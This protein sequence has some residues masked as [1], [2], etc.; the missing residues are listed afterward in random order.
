MVQRSN[1]EVKISL[2]DCEGTDEE[3]V[4]MVVA[5]ADSNE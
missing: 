5:V 2:Q 1:S 3:E 4:V